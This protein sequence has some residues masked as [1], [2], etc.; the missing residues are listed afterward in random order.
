V[1]LP[2]NPLEPR[3][4]R[5]VIK[6]SEPLEEACYL[7]ATR[8][9]AYDLPPGWSMS[10]DE[11]MNIMGTEPTGKPVFYR[12]ADE[13]LPTR[14]TNDRGDDVTSSIARADFLPQLV[15]GRHS[16]RFPRL[17]CLEDRHGFMAE[18]WGGISL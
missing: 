10:L 12:G 17:D 13:L 11:R 4:N 8:L 15:V 3:D 16:W 2:L 14:A 6:L 7:Y 5:F 9:V 1:H 18:H